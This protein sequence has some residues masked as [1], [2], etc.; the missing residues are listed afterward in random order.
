[1]TLDA[2]PVALRAAGPAAGRIRRL[3]EGELGWQAIDDASAEVVLADVAGAGQAGRDGLPAVLL[4][5]GDDDP[6]RAAEA[7]RRL[8]PAEVL[9][10]PPRS[11]ETLRD[12]VA[13]AVR[14]PVRTA[15]TG[16][17]LRVGGAAGGV[18]TTTVA[19]AV[20]GLVAWAGRST[21]VVTHG[22]VPHPTGPSV[23]ADALASPTLGA[24]MV[25]VRGVPRLRLVHLDEPPDHDPSLALD[26]PVVVDR[27]RGVDVDV[28]VT[29]RDPAGLD[30]IGRTPAST[31]V[32]ADAGAVPRAALRAAAGGRRVVVL[33]WS[34]RVAR[35]A[36]LGRV[37][38]SLPG[39]WLRLLRPV[40]E[41]LGGEAA[42]VPPLTQ[43]AVVGA[44]R[45]AS[46]ARRWDRGVVRG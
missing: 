41:E 1:M 21:V 7:V 22:P 28:L 45:A 39:S 34:A 27:G 44:D 36:A 42:S 32:V 23:A 19:L 43:D 11:A 14:P 8:A 37:P 20:A 24:A 13:A 6:L 35:A 25:A 26:D 16:P 18:G 3:V 33:P 2:L 10:W 17:V 9:T 12:A 38:A 4:V 46:T 5:A 29:R 15:G 40:A 30:A 31:I